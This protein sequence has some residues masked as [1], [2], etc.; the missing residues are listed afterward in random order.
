MNYELTDSEKQAMIEA[1]IESAKREIF[2]NRINIA[3]W[4]VMEGDWSNQIANS[5]Q[6]ISNLTASIDALSDL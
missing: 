2:E 5:E 6:A 3:K 1:E 4:Q